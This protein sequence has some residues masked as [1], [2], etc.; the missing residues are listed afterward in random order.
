MSVGS[1][2][3]PAC[4]PTTVYG[5]DLP[6]RVFIGNALSTTS[7]IAAITVAAL[8]AEELTGSARYAGIPSALGTA[9][10]ALGASILTVASSWW[11][12]RVAFSLGFAV[13]TCGGVITSAALWLSSLPL[14]LAGM[15]VLGFGRSVTQLSRFAAGDLWEVDKRASAIGFVVWAGTIGSF[16]GPLMVVPASRLGART[17]GSE[18]AGPYGLATLGF[19]LATLWFFFG[20]RPEPLE[21]AVTT[22]EDAGREA[23]PLSALLRH[24]NVLLGVLVLMISQGVMI[25]VMTMTPVHIHG[26]GHG[27]SLVSW[28][29]ATHSVAMFAFSPLTG[30]L[31]DRW[32]GR[33]VMAAGAVM[34]AAS[35]ILAAQATEAQASILLIALFLLGVGWNFGFVAA[36]TVLQ[37]GMPLADRLRLQGFADAL[38]WASGGLAAFGSG[39]VMAS[40]SYAGLSLLGAG[41]SALPLVALVWEKAAGRRPLLT[42]A[43]LLYIDR[44][45]VL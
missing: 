3:S 15:F 42:P 22:D 31:V 27:L 26:H 1:V 11:G 20:L 5:G 19:L 9:A 38:T 17:L 32:G 8:A 44:S 36:S 43:S 21:L 23:R 25:L 33:Q 35:A 30:W 41:L 40:G 14:F 34:L 29:M 37:E 12:R 10:S 28:V 2:E 7:F 16:L 45:P 6:G 24:P 18:L 39:F 13:S 4:P